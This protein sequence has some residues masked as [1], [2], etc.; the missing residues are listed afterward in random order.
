MKNFKK[1]IPLFVTVILFYFGYQSQIHGQGNCELTEDFSEYTGFSIQAVSCSLDVCILNQAQQ[2]AVPGLL[3]RYKKVCTK[4]AAKKCLYKT[5]LM[6]ADCQVIIKTPPAFTATTCTIDTA[7][8]AWCTYGI[9][10][11]YDC[12]CAY[13]KVKI[14]ASNTTGNYCPGDNVVLTAVPDSLI[15]NIDYIQWFLNDTLLHND[16][17]FTH[18][19]AS[20]GNY[21]VLIVDTDGNGYLSPAFPV[22]CAS[23][24]PTLQQWALIILAVLL[25]IIGVLVIL[26]NKRAAIR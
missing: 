2:N 9:V 24:I 8:Q 18:V 17:T 25:L 20:T 11:Y 21:E 3:E 14:T 4:N 1:S 16:T 13:N 22:Q 15:P 7:G 19:V 5:C 6:S 10:G 26:R 12:D 23:A